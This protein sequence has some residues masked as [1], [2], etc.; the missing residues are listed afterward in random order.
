M[1]ANNNA[2]RCRDG[3]GCANCNFL[4][5]LPLTSG[6]P[7]DNFTIETGSASIDASGLAIDPG[8]ILISTT[9]NPD[10]TFVIRIN[11]QVTLTDS[12]EAWIILN[13]VDANNYKYV[14]IR[15][16]PSAHLKFFQVAAGVTSEYTDTAYRGFVQAAGTLS[17]CVSVIVAEQWTVTVNGRG[18]YSFFAP[19]AADWGLGAG[20][21]TPVF[22][23]VSAKA[24]GEGCPACS[25]PICPESIDQLLGAPTGHSLTAQFDATFDETETCEACP[26][27]GGSQLYKIDRTSSFYI[28]HACGFDGTGGTFL[29]SLSAYYKYCETICS[30]DIETLLFIQSILGTV[31]A[32]NGQCLV[33]ATALIGIAKIDHATFPESAS[34]N[35][36][37]YGDELV[38]TTNIEGVPPGLQTVELI[39]ID[40]FNRR[41]NASEPIFKIPRNCGE[42]PSV[43]GPFPDEFRI[44]IGSTGDKESACND[45]DG[46]RWWMSKC[47]TGISTDPV[48][49]LAGPNVS[50]YVDRTTNPS[51]DVDKV[52]RIQIDDGSDICATIFGLIDVGGPTATLVDGPFDACTDC[53]TTCAACCDQYVDRLT[54]IL[55]TIT[56]ST[57]VDPDCS[58]VANG[59]NATKAGRSFTIPFDTG[60]CAGTIIKTIPF[61][62]TPG[63]CGLG[64][65]GEGTAVISI[66]I[67][68]NLDGTYSLT[69]NI[70][71]SGNIFTINIAQYKKTLAC[72]DCQ[73]GSY[74]LAIDPDF[75][76][77][78]SA[79]APL[80]VEFSGVDCSEFEM[81]ARPTTEKE[82]IALSPGTRFIAPDGSIRMV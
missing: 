2:M 66:T 43:C 77:V 53:L 13:G 56:S 42:E 27:I 15:V 73:A 48:T 22:K 54:I 71:I 1:S 14:S 32:A 47:C 65:S 9:P 70:T 68:D 24:I 6:D 25:L 75:L 57:V 10:P 60:S 69:I 52:Y 31:T 16:G 59:W 4:G 46:L 79:S 33:W 67:T 35:W 8:S 58:N 3:C 50:Y 76:Q 41:K 34:A 62:Y 36:L 82:A 38:G 7:E 12:D 29:S 19:T 40:E 23:N 44:F 64:D 21:G 61:I 81:L 18:C 17:F 63:G 20:V 74:G 28:P 39:S 45:A 78:G 26:D 55:P 30:G 5:P 72:F 51:L 49:G 11:G 80:A 37:F